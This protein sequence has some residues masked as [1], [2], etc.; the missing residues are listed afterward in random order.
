MA[1]QKVY[2]YVIRDPRNGEVFYVGR[3]NSYA[4]RFGQH[5]REAELYRSQQE[6]RVA[7]LFQ[8]QEVSIKARSRKAG[9]NVR[10]LSRINSIVDSGQA[11]IFEVID[12]WEVLDVKY[13]NQLEEA[14]IAE[15]RMRGAPLTN[16]ITSHRMN[17]W[18]YNPKR[19]GWKSY[20]ADSPM[21]Y[22][23]MIKS[24]PQQEKKKRVVNGSL[25]DKN[26]IGDK[27]QS[28]FDVST[29]FDVGDVTLVTSMD[30]YFEQS[31][32]GDV[33]ANKFGKRRRKGKATG[34]ANQRR[35]LPK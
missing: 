10:K 24:K 1:M 7:T 30:S 2:I 20:Y 25:Y 22:I 33:Y 26:S 12:T 11:P 6:N 35:K 32:S 21:K 27:T 15:Y 17:P 18:W 31:Y 14:W 8:M 5:L 19:A 4:E 29:N 16:Y 23:E 9:Q 28:A 34:S 3:T 13:A